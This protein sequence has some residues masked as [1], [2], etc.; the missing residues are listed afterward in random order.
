M[1]EGYLLINPAQDGLAS[2]Q[3]TTQEYKAY[4]TIRNSIKIY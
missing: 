2:N 4:D 1:G 3:M